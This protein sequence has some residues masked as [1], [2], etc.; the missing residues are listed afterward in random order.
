MNMDQFWRSIDNL[1]D[2]NPV[3]LPS[4]DGGGGNSKKPSD[5]SMIVSAILGN[6]EI[7]PAGG[8]DGTKADKAEPVKGINAGTPAPETGVP[9]SES[10][11][12]DASGGAKGGGLF[13]TLAKVLGGIF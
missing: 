2:G 3:A 12:T 4:K 6:K 11:M 8:A 9:T 10:V 5:L 13:K 1:A 7:K